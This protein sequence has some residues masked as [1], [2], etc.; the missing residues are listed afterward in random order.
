MSLIKLAFGLGLVVLMLPTDEAA[1]AKV[2][3]TAATAAHRA[4]TFCD[5]NPVTCDQGAEAWAT[6]KEKAAFGGRMA[7]TLLVERGRATEAASEGPPHDAP[8]VAASGQAMPVARRVKTE[9]VPVS[10]GTLTARDL[11]PKWRG[12][13]QGI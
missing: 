6:F 2:F 7:W 8:V 10:R 5:R 13:R 4:A 9:T 3:S 11:E 12:P 1:Q